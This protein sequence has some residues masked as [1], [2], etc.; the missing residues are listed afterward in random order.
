MTPSPRRSPSGRARE[1]ERPARRVRSGQARPRPRALRQRR[2]I[3]RRTSEQPD[4]RRGVDRDDDRERSPDPGG[5]GDRVGGAK[6]S[7]DH[8][9]LAPHLGQR[10][11]PPPARAYDS[12]A[13]Q[14]A[15][16][17]EPARRGRSRRR[18]QANRN[19]TDSSASALADPSMTSNAQVD[20]GGRRPV[21]RRDGVEPD[22]AR[23][24]VKS[25]QER[26]QIRNGNAAGRDAVAASGRRAARGRGWRSRPPSPSPRT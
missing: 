18:H 1:A 15:G 9:G 14:R 23:V 16:A 19:Q 4:A 21:G 12:E 11:I 13:G 17:Q 26:R 10:P 7:V 20:D 6:E 5:V 2:D 3:P 8:P 25:G 22:D 24:G